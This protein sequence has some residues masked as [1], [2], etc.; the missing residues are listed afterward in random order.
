MFWESRRGAPNTVEI[1]KLLKASPRLRFQGK[2]LSVQ[3][4]GRFHRHWIDERLKR[5]AGLLAHLDQVA[6]L[7]RWLVGLDL[8]V[9]LESKRAAPQRPLQRGSL[10]EEAR[11]L[12]EPD[13]LDVEFCDRPE[14]GQLRKHS[15]CDARAKIGEW[16]RR[17]VLSGKIG[18]L[19]A[20]NRK[21]T[22]FGLL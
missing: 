3:R 1:V 15:E 21:R 8:N 17:C 7:L 16:G 18:S 12:F 19:I 4:D 11:H 14:P 22:A 9:S 5:E 6:D 20:G 13:R 2:R 10:H